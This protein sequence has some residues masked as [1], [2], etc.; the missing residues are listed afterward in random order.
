MMEKGIMRATK[1]MKAPI[2]IT[3]FSFFENQFIIHLFKIIPPT[4][5]VQSFMFIGVTHDKIKLTNKKHQSRQGFLLL[6]L[7]SVLAGRTYINDK[8]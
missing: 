8:M 2:V 5:P 4:K 1:A 7:I 6:A 3:K